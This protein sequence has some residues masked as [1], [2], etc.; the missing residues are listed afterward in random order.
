LPILLLALAFVVFVLVLGRTV[1][2]REV[3]AVGGNRKAA[4]FS[5]IRADA[6]G[7]SVYVISGFLAALG[8][9][10]LASRMGSA[11]PSFGSG[12]AL[13]SIA[14]VILGGVSLKGGKG[15]LVGAFWGVLIM[16][17]LAIGL[18][19]IGL[20]PYYQDIASGFILLAAVF[21]DINRKG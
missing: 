2:G 1:Y 19:A 15:S 8:G 20:E 4:V 6:V 12:F 9:L 21:F 11:Q 13:N 7:I 3:F 17:V 10:V 16:Q 18:I 14:A 5:G